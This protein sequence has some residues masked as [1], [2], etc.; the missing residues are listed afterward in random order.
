MLRE[1]LAENTDNSKK[2]IKI[3]A[4]SVDNTNY[5]KTKDAWAK[6]H[7]GEYTA[8]LEDTPENRRF[9]SFLNRVLTQEEILIGFGVTV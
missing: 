5:L 9:V 7:N 8:L 3:T 2:Y 4:K 6:E 1:L